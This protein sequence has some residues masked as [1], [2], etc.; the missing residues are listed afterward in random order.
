MIDDI[1]AYW[2]ARPCNIRHSDLPVGTREFY[3]AVE[4]R[5]Y[6]VEN[7][8]PGFAEFS[9]WEGQR[10]LEI[11]CGLGTD[12]VNFARAGADY[13]GVDLSPVSLALAKQRFAVFGLQGEFH[14]GDAEHLQ[15]FLPVKRYD[16]IY[17]FGVIHH[18]MDPGAA[19][20][21]LLPYLGF[22]SEFRFM[23]YARNSWKAWLAEA[24]LVQ[25]EAQAGCPQV[26]TYTEADL[27]GLVGD[28]RIFDV[29]QTH[30][31]PYQVEKYV[32]HEYE[33][34]PWF[35]AMPKAMFDLLEKKLG[36]HLLVRCGK[37]YD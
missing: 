27:P 11:G 29:R 32:Q 21:A 25:W 13:T 20:R 24:G 15:D 34:E 6:L 9:K 33:F 18:S 3:H 22:H 5:K 16:L 30:L 31:F 12:A 7:H 26:V 14:C 10:V 19:V 37:K 17:S 2:D 4:K 28:L 35:K 8:I 36:H 1:R 23:V